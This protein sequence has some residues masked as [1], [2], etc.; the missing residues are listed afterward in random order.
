[1]VFD[2]THIRLTILPCAKLRSSVDN[3]QFVGIFSA[4]YG[5]KVAVL[6][7]FP[8]TFNFISNAV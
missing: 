7:I 4:I 6:R 2:H 3:D 5:A 1:M 8:N